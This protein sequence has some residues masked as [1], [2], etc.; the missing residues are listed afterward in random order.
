MS[1]ITTFLQNEMLTSHNAWFYTAWQ[2]DQKMWFEW[3]S[4]GHFWPRRGP[5]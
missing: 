2:G 5:V 1:N 3:K 4:M